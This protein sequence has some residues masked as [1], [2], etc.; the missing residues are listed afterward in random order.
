MNESF[1][2]T[3]FKSLL[4]YKDAFDIDYPQEEV[5]GQT[6]VHRCKYCTVLTTQMNGRLENHRPTC[7]YRM[8]K[9]GARAREETAQTAA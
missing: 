9:T 8:Q 3:S 5:P 6:Q 4:P 2:P 7:E 1:D